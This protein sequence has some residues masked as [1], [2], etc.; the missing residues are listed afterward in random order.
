MVQENRKVP[1]N[2]KTKARNI[3]KH[4]KC[5]RALNSDDPLKI[6]NP[7]YYREK[8]ND[9]LDEKVPSWDISY[10]KLKQIYDEA[11]F[12]TYL[13]WEMCPN[14]NI[15]RRIPWLYAKDGLYFI[16]QQHLDSRYFTIF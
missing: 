6:I 15:K 1:K 2:S 4:R 9:D 3:R 11:R 12:D 16:L 10:E 13:D 14:T 7:R 8:L 5:F